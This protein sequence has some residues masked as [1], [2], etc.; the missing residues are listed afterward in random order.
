MVPTVP[1]LCKGCSM[2]R[3]M[4]IF[5]SGG[6]TMPRDMVAR[7][8][9]LLFFK[10]AGLLALLAVLLYLSARTILGLSGLGLFLIGGLIY[11]MVRLSGDAYFIP[12]NARP[13]SRWEAPEVYRLLDLLSERAGIP[14]V[15]QLYLVPSPLMNALT[16]GPAERPVIVV[17]DTLLSS[18]P[19]R[20]LAGVLAHEI[21]HIRNGDLTLFRMVEIVRQ[22]TEMVSQAGW[23]LLVFFFFPF[24]LF[25]RQ[26]QPLSFF[27]FMVASPILSLLLALALQRTREFQADLTAAELTGDPQGLAMALYRITSPRYDILGA[28]FPFGRSLRRLERE[29][30]LFLSHP[31]T[32]ERIRRLLSLRA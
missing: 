29:H 8:K 27:L 21:A 7:E 15:P 4:G 11:L 20:E 28:L 24:L 16:T 10:S 1:F 31:P 12:A 30:S 9:M 3:S 32:E 2:G 14:Q 18:L 25:A 17:T 19:P 23:V 5:S 26:V 13:L 22:F 6:R